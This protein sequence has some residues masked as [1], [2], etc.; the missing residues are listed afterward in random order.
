[1]PDWSYHTIFKPILHRLSSYKSREF[2]HR[3][4]SL[5]ASVPFGSHFIN[6]LGRH[7]SS[8]ALSQQLDG[9]TFANPV[10][11]SGKIDPLLTGT[12]AFTH[13]GFGLLEIGPITLAQ[14]D[15]AHSP[16]VDTENQSIEFPSEQGSIGLQATV[17]KL[18]SVKTTQPIFLRLAGTDRE[19]EKLILT[20]DPYADGFIIDNKEE[21]LIHLTSKPIYCAISSEQELEE[22][23]FELH[24]GFSGILVC[25]DENKVDDYIS[26]IKNI[27]H[28]GYSKT[29]ITSGGITEPQHAL[30]VIEAGANL[31]LLAGDYVFSGPGLT[32][33]INEAMLSKEELPTEQQKGWRAYW[34]FGLFICIGGLLALLFSVTWIILPYDE[35]FLG[36]K[37][38]EIFQFNKRIMLFMA[39]DRMT[40]AGTMISGGIIYMNLAK[41]GI[42]HGMK[43]A[44][45]ATDAA[46]ILGFLG[47]FS[48]I[49]FG[50][51]DWLHLLFWLVLLPFYMRGFFSTR[52]ISGTP[53]SNNRRNH[54]IWKRSVWGQFLFVILGFSFILGGIVISLYGVTSVFVPTDLLYICMSPEQLQSFNDRL[55]PVIAHDRAGFGSALLSVGLLVLMLSLWG[56][57]QGNKWMW[58][59]YLVG[60]LPAFITAISIHIAIGYTTFI[61]L[62]PAYF[63]IL[64]Y[65][66]GLVTTYSF[67]HKGNEE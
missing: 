49:G 36:V 10:G 61:H 44:K 38:I 28:C 64:L 25:F 32:K 2:I 6:F 57:H 21:S 16:S 34:L 43:W 31:V 20:L 26:K 54:R 17:N 65:T 8:P 9:I 18:K 46:A 60:G 48:F 3:G 53:T 29:I 22:S 24:S 15:S 52:G 4:M 62:L 27:K 42:R 66:G 12:K 14:K 58:W 33:R 55:I 39:H 47:I 23:I 59:T 63:A 45:Q 11:L 41:H 13:L 1:M 37:K 19:V 35:A 50:Y 51:F 67:F 7:E 5:V 56:F 30:D 40:L